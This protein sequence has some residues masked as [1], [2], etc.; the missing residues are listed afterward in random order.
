[1]T[2]QQKKSSDTT[3]LNTLISQNDAK[4]LEKKI[5]LYKIAIILEALP[6]GFDK[7]V[8]FDRIMEMTEK[9]LEIIYK[10]SIQDN[11]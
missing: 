9:E 8:S 1:M 6:K 7:S 11:E 2:D 3:L 4:R 5:I 10:Q